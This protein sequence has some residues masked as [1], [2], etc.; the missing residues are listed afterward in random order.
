MNDKSRA[1]V[2]PG[3][4]E[5]QLLRHGPPHNQL[6]SP[7]TEYLALCGDHPNT[8]LRIPLEHS[9]LETRLRALNYR[10][11][12]ETRIDQLREMAR[13]AS[14]LLARVP[15]LIAD[16]SSDR[17]GGKP[18]VH[19][20]IAS[21][22]SEL[23]LFPFEL[24]LA[25]DGFPGAGQALC[26]Q[27][28]LP[29]CLTRRSKN[30]RNDGFD[31]DRSFK[32]LL[33]A[34]DAGGEIPLQQHYALLRK[35]VEPWVGTMPSDDPDR[36]KR[37]RRRVLRLLTQ[38]NVDKIQRTLCD[39]VTD[40]GEPFTHIHVLAH[41]C[42]LPETDRRSGI[43]L[44]HPT[45]TGIDGVDGRRLAEA[46]GCLPDFPSSA[47]RVFGP[48]VVTLA[49]CG[50]AEQGSVKI[51][52]ASLAFELHDSGI[53]LVVGSQFPL[54]ADGSVIMTEAFYRGLLAGRD[55]RSTIWETRQALQANM[56]QLP[57]L[58]G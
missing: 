26:L 55:P 7:L 3:L 25:P 22:A 28:R 6:L 11:S 2:P 17:A 49:T 30:V 23:A 47:K 5:L 10:D 15:G 37:K 38:A 12:E 50:S 52:G 34:S 32:I 19:L 21:R 35:L 56:P 44:H 14:E 29:V 4:V 31:W 40:T 53:P 8:T 39:E 36:K 58:G 18:F 51:P 20:S 41:G 42:D 43:A 27:K 57:A 16:L 1:D 45:R 9:A 13:I 33:V 24:A 46:L 54:S 48:T